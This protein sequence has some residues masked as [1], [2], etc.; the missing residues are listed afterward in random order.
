ILN[1]L[2]LLGGAWTGSLTVYAILFGNDTLKPWGCIHCCC[3]RKTRS[4]LRESFPTMPL[5][6]S[7]PLSSSLSPDSSTSSNDLLLQQ[8]ALSQQLDSLELFLKEYVV[9]STYLED[10]NNNEYSNKLSKLLEK[11]RKSNNNNTTSKVDAVLPQISPSD[12]SNI[13]DISSYQLPV[14]HFT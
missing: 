14:P 2:G 5:K 11:L 3:A 12:R 1:A 13:Q 6:S 4:L 10:S 9:D 7:R 8:P